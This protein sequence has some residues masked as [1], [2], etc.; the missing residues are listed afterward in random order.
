MLEL[1]TIHKTKEETIGKYISKKQRIFNS[2]NDNRKN[3]LNNELFLKAAIIA[4]LPHKYQE[5]TCS[6]NI[7]EMTVADLQKKLESIPRGITN[8]TKKTSSISV[9]V[10]RKKIGSIASFTY[11][12]GWI[13]FF[14]LVSG[15]IGTIFGIIL[16]EIL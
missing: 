15:V 9:S 8:K 1:L 7:S 12:L 4:G 3:E 5:I 10:P 14:C 13:L 2:L 6:W 11:R 16:N